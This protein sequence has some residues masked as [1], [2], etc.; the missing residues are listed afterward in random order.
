MLEFIVGSF[1]YFIVGFFDNNFYSVV[2]IIFPFSSMRIVFSACETFEFADSTSC[3]K[4]CKFPFSSSC[5]K[6]NKLFVPNFFTIHRE[7]NGRV[8]YSFW[9]NSKISLAIW[10]R[11]F[12]SLVIW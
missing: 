2:T 10:L 3:A 8:L 11:G 12:F 4:W 1:S 6:Q 9:I 7:Q 5:F